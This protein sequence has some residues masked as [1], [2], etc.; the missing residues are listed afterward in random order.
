M[1]RL[2][3]LLQLA[4]ALGRFIDRNPGAMV[5]I[6]CPPGQSGHPDTVARPLDE[7][8]QNISSTRGRGS[9]VPTARN[10]R[11]ES[12]SSYCFAAFRAGMA[13]NTR[14]KPDCC[15]SCRGR[16]FSRSRKETTVGNPFQAMM[17][18]PWKGLS[19]GHTDYLPGIKP[20]WSALAQVVG[21]NACQMTRHVKSF[22]LPALGGFVEGLNPRHVKVNKQPRDHGL[23]HERYSMGD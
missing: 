23:P 1:L 9:G 18:T 14:V 8:F 3:C 16:L 15:A 20:G 6:A 17:D 5:G 4:V 19:V 12:P 22:L 7:A 13:R 11:Q 21:M 10:Q 2:F